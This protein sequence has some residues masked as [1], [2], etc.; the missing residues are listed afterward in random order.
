ML[1]MDPSPAASVDGDP[2][3]PLNESARCGVATVMATIVTAI[4]NT[5]ATTSATGCASAVASSDTSDATA[6]A[7]DATTPQISAAVRVSAL[8]T[9]PRAKGT[10]V[11]MSFPV[12]SRLSAKQVPRS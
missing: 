2:T 7:I 9:A 6:S 12:A 1:V 11:K 5:N 3:N 8:M 4:P 10:S